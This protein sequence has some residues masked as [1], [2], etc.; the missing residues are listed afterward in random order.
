MNAAAG[1][2]LNVIVVDERDAVE[3]DDA[4]VGRVGLYFAYVDCL[5][6]LVRVVTRLQRADQMQHLERRQE[7]VDA[8]HEA[9]EKDDFGQANGEHFEIARKVVQVVE[10]LQL[11]GGAE[12]EHEVL[13]ILTLVG[14]VVQHVGCY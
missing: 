13:E 5:V 4:Q 10:V 12:V 2:R 14:Q 9:L 3:V 8:T 6:R 7:R 11:H 1:D